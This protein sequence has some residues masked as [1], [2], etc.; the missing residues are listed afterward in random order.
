VDRGVNRSQADR[1]FTSPKSHHGL[2]PKGKMAIITCIT[3]GKSGIKNK[4]KLPTVWE[5]DPS[6]SSRITWRKIYD[7]LGVSDRLELAALLPASSAA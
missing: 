6:R 7:K 1:F 5:Y 3:Q 2:S 4:K